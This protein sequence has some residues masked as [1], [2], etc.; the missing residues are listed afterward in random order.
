L[1]IIRNSADEGWQGF[2][3]NIVAYCGQGCICPLSAILF[4][5]LTVGNSGE[6]HPLRAMSDQNPVLAYS[7][8]HAGQLTGADDGFISMYHFHIPHFDQ[9]CFHHD[10]G[11]C[12]G[13]FL[14]VQFQ[15]MKLLEKNP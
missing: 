7:L 1:Y 13:A 10:T 9:I 8:P 14:A 3:S 12:K 11:I 4:L 5:A 15:R 2:G 6:E